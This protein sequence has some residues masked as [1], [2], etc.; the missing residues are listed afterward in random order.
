MATHTLSSHFKAVGLP[1]GELSCRAIRTCGSLRESI[2]LHSLYLYS[3]L[4][5]I[6][7]RVVSQFLY[8]TGK[9]EQKSVSRFLFL[10]FYFSISNFTWYHTSDTLCTPT[11]LV[12]GP[13]TFV[14]SVLPRGR[15]ELR[16]LST[17]QERRELRELSKAGWAAP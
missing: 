2:Y 17:I 9:S 14:K 8:T 11:P 13:P 1:S 3:R 10:D 6:T 4:L 16:E 5:F 7:L 12:Y 15:R